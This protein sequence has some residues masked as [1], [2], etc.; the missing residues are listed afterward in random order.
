MLGWSDDIE[1]LTLAN[2]NFR[3]VVVTGKN[4]QVVVMSL[5]VGEEIGWEVHPENDQFFRL[6]QGEV[7]V[8][9][10]AG[11]DAIDETHSAKDAWAFVV[12]AGT[13]H[14]VTNVGKEPVKL[15]TIYSPPHHP[16]G[17]VH[18]TKAEADADE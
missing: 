15:Y 3:D 7:R 13:F 14:N 11:E 4:S 9:L 12:T 1:K 17:T 5:A 6:E 16:A 2:E 18:A 10:G 8:D